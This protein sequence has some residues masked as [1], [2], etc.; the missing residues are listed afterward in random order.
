LIAY[1]RMVDISLG[2]WDDAHQVNK[3]LVK[4]RIVLR[5]I[6]IIYKLPKVIEWIIKNKLN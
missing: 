1:A 3:L 4:T 2:V 5:I 6:L